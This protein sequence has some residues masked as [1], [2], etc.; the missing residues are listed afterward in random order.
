MTNVCND[1]MTNENKI[2]EMLRIDFEIF[3]EEPPNTIWDK[4]FFFNFLCLYYYHFSFI[5]LY[6]KK[7]EQHELLH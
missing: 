4:I 1:W 3:V 5:Y 6:K 2:P 7:Y